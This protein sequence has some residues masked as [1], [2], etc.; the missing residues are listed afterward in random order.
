MAASAFVRVVDGVERPA[1]GR[2]PV[3]AGH[4]IWREAGLTGR[5]RRVG[6]TAGGML[7]V[8]DR[9]VG[10]DLDLELDGTGGPVAIRY[11][12]AVRFD[13]ERAALGQ[14]PVD[15][16]LTVD[17]R[18]APLAAAIRYHGVFRRAAGAATWLAV[19]ITIGRDIVTNCPPS[20]ITHPILGRPLRL[21]A[22]IDATEPTDR[23]LP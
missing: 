8:D 22:D 3:A 21:Q 4:S 20:R 17:G 14:W 5:R 19:R 11:Q 23:S 2:W 15:G 10:I 7:I 18:S 12:G 9:T 1:P 16:V 6:R 13:D